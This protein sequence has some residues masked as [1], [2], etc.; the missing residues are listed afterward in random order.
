[1][2]KL[3]LTLAAAAVVLL[4][5]QSLAL[6]CCLNDDASQITN[7]D[8]EVSSY[9]DTD[10]GQ[11]QISILADNKEQTMTRWSFREINLSKKGQFLEKPEGTVTAED[12]VILNSLSAEAK[13]IIA[14]HDQFR[15]KH[16]HINWKEL[17][18]TQDMNLN[19]TKYTVPFYA[20]FMF[21]GSLEKKIK[22]KKTK[23]QL[24]KKESPTPQK[25]WESFVDDASNLAS[26]I[27]DF[28]SELPRIQ[29]DQGTQVLLGS[30]TLNVVNGTDL[31]LDV[32]MYDETS[33]LEEFGQMI[34]GLYTSEGEVVEHD[35]ERIVKAVMPALTKGIEMDEKLI[36]AIQT[37][38]VIKLPIGGG[39]LILL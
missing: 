24:A 9:P 23:K 34:S 31:V 16:L 33:P 21:Y 11:E 20:R 2:N 12:K 32:K 15:I 22:V 35:T 17:K 6:P 14:S 27:S 37:R 13:A 29:I 10:D 7:T 8:I 3:K 28:A 19:I 18:S 26:Q 4:S 30:I 38:K 25:G 1:M 36:N 5:Q 39:G